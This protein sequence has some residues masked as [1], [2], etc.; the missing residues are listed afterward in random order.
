M[1]QRLL[2]C[3]SLFIVCSM[4]CIALPSHAQEDE[5]RDVS[6]VNTKLPDSPGLTH[7]VLSSQAMEHDVGYV[8]WTPPGY[9]EDSGKRYPVI[10]F[11]HGMGGNESADSGG[12]SSRVAGAI[13]DG[14]VPPVICVFPNGGRSGYRNEVER[15]IIDELIPTI[16]HNYRTIAKASSRALAGFSMGGMGSVRLVAAYPELFCLAASWGG[17]G[18]SGD[19]A[20]F[21]AVK[22]NAD[23]FKQNNTAFLQIRGDSDR[24]TEGNEAFAKQLDE[25]GITNEYIVLNDTSHNLGH[26]YERS[27]D[28]M[29]AFIGRHI[30]SKQITLIR[31]AED[32]SAGN[33]PCFRIETPNAIYY[34]EKTGAGLSSLIDKDGNDW[35]SFHPEPGSGAGG[36]YRGFPNAVHQQDGSFFHPKN[37]DTEPSTVTL[38]KETGDQV[39]FVATT[40][41]ETWQAQWDFYP[42]HCTFTMTRMPE[43][44]RYWVLYE[45]T[46]GGDYEDD[47]WWMTSAITEKQPLTQPHEGDIP[48]PEC[49]AFGDK[50][51]QR[52]LVLLH[53]RDDDAIDR[54][55]QMQHK[56]T[57]FGFGRK[58]IEKFL[59]SVPRQF[60]IGFVESNTHSGISNAVDGM[61]NP[62]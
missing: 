37:E 22:D 59:D 23:V 32:E 6:W 14:V 61:L 1:F 26:Y 56:M 58:G 27:S 45:G 44:Y 2:V 17:G 40:H 36:E 16:D 41:T 50:D 33:L 29:M 53:H 31:D 28:Q 24:F 7:H 30:Q 54:F 62:D 47:D 25:L 55:Y 60:S 38:M 21:D 42:T 13:K 39:S 49:I 8:V 3:M 35:L 11:L 10:Y 34:L 19:T 46:P 51:L 43:G 4:I 52:S 18:R 48:A 5:R 57:V 9:D 15:M 20:T 12:F